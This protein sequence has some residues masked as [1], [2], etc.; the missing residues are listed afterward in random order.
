[1]YFAITQDFIKDSITSE[2]ITPHVEY[3]YKLIDMGIVVVSGPFSDKQRGGMFILEAN[4]ENEARKLVEN[5]PAVKF[6]ILKN[7]IRSYNLMFLRKTENGLTN[8]SK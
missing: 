6:G 5:D 4:N 3:I 2:M 1:M 8:R 7:N